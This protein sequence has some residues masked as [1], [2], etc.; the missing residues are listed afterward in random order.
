M[1]PSIHLAELQ[2][3][4]HL[5]SD[6]ATSRPHMEPGLTGHTYVEYD[7]R[8]KLQT[9]VAKRLRAHENGLGRFGRCVVVPH[10]QVYDGLGWAVVVWGCVSHGAAPRI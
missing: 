6:V 2:G 5:D 9:Q 1:R 8:P 4:I 3:V 7:S 10:G